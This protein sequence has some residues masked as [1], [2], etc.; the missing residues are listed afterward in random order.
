MKNVQNQ[1]KT[2]ENHIK[3]CIWIVTECEIF[4][5][6]AFNMLIQARPQPAPPIGRQKKFR[7]LVNFMFILI[8]LAPEYECSRLGDPF[9]ANESFRGLMFDIALAV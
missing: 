5:I 7:S 4:L 1:I 9:R 6:P 3:S 2:Y 8:F